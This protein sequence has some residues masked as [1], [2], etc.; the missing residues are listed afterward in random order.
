MDMSVI[1]S[2]FIFLNENIVFLRLNERNP[3]QEKIKR[4]KYHQQTVAYVKSNAGNFMKMIQR[5]EEA[6]ERK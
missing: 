4:D 5:Y 3:Y 1:I 2:L 6:N